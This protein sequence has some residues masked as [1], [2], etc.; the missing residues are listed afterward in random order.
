MS[1]E[2]VK[3]KPLEGYVYYPEGTPRQVIS[4]LQH[5]RAEHT[6]LHLCYGDPATGEDWNE[7]Y[8]CTGIIG[9]TTGPEPIPI[10]LYNKRSLGGTA[11][12]TKNIIKITTTKGNRVLYQHP[13]YHQPAEPEPADSRIQALLHI[14]QVNPPC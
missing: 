10:L 2:A 11:V 6:R 3:F 12:L 4:V 13:T 14:L 5:A 7:I 8:D 9:R 1:E